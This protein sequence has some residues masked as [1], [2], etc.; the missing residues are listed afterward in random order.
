MLMA[1]RRIETGIQI[2]RQRN[3]C[4]RY[5]Q[6]PDWIQ[7]IKSSSGV[8]TPGSLLSVHMAPPG[9]AGM[10]FKPTVLTVAPSRDRFGDRPYVL[11][12]F[13]AKQA[14][15]TADRVTAARKRHWYGAKRPR[16]AAV[17]SSKG[18][19]PSKRAGPQ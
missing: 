6:F 5:R 8:L 4:G 17:R 11:A 10:R 19:G 15:I 9:K 3:G 13:G 14:S 12:H 18:P 16:D 7:F 1:E 2:G